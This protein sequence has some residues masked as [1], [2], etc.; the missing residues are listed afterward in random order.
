MGSPLLEVDGAAVTRFAGGSK[1]FDSYRG[2]AYQIDDQQGRFVTLT[3]V[4]AFRIAVAVVDDQYPDRAKLSED[5]LTE[6]A[7]PRNH[8]DISGMSLR[9]YLAARCIQTV[10]AAGYVE[11]ELVADQCYR[12][13]DAM[14]V[15]RKA[16]RA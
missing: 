14:L 1:C 5:D 9:D 4:Q 10:K 8:D 7:F 3:P 6:E 13:A 2:P 12:L 11:H 15:A 16:V